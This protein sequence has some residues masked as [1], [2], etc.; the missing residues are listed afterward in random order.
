M[1][2]LFSA[3]CFRLLSIRHHPAFWNS[4][5]ESVMSSPHDVEWIYESTFLVMG[6][7][8]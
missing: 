3:R 6:W 7:E 2:K 4:A 8:T 5:T 1:S